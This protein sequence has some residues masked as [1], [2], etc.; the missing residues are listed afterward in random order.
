MWRSGHEY[1]FSDERHS[2]RQGIT[3]RAG[4][5]LNLLNTL[6]EFASKVVLALSRHSLRPPFLALNAVVPKARGDRE[7]VERKEPGTPRVE[8]FCRGSPWN[9]GVRTNSGEHVQ[10]K[11]FIVRRERQNFVVVVRSFVC[12]RS[13]P[14]ATNAAAPSRVVSHLA[15]A[16]VD[17]GPREGA[18]G[19]GCVLTNMFCVFRSRLTTTTLFCC[20]S[21]LPAERHGGRHGDRAERHHE[22]RDQEELEDVDRLRPR[23]GGKLVHGKTRIIVGR[24]RVYRS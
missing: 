3:R 13:R 22:Q 11:C 4:D 24:A 23:R 7:E 14:L 12:V 18:T 21:V 16:S 5:K 8:S 10:T 2:V 9:G 15:W 6:K 1:I 17:V 20:W 19:D